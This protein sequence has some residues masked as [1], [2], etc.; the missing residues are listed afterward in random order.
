MK[1]PTSSVDA[2][3]TGVHRPL[4]LSCA[5][6][7]S[8]I[9]SG[10]ALAQQA[11][12]TVSCG[13]ASTCN[14]TNT[15][16]ALS[17]SLVSQG[18][19]WANFS[20]SVEQGQRSDA[21]TTFSGS[22]TITNAGSAPATVGNILVNLQRK[23][24]KTWRTVAT[25]IA[26]AAIGDAAT[27]AL[28]CSTAS[29]ES[30]SSFNENAAS[31][32]M[33]FTDADNNTLFAIND[34]PFV[35]EA[36]ASKTLNYTAKFNNSLLGIPAGEQIR[37]EAIV[38]FANSGGRGGSGASCSG[39]DVNGSGSVDTV[40]RWVRSVPCRTTVSLP[41]MEASN[42]SV[43]L[44]DSPA[45]VSTT[46]TVAMA[47]FDTDIGGGSG[48]ALLDQSAWFYANT[49]VD[50]GAEGGS[51]T[52][53]ATLA[54]AQPPA[55]NEPVALHAEA[56]AYFV[57]EPP[58]SGTDTCSYTQGGWGATPH[59]NNPASL[60]AGGFP[61]VYPSG[62]KVGGGRW[63]HFTS[64]SAVSAYLPAGRTAGGLTSNLTN[65]TTSSAGV[66]GG[67]VLALQLNVDFSNAGL[68]P[69]GFGNLIVDGGLTVSNILADANAALGGAPG[70]DISALNEL[71]SS[72]NESMDNCAATSWAVQHFNLSQ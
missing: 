44:N 46:G 48:A 11:S 57:V 34:P 62:V 55:C 26:N 42:A 43:V 45:S 1:T 51:L 33:N 16:W 17:K 70:Y 72:L 3:R 21:V 9:F 10:V 50:A 19:S 40:E 15:P 28:I 35:L 23:S 5:L 54:A 12:L 7:L 31:G 71:V 47:G 59:G 66:F 8:A 25:D 52:N 63:M 2:V 69:F 32:A 36:G 53:V 39:V 22:L 24:G 60:L 41:I 58:T 61:S 20:V 6:F 56:T 4:L 49:T 67:Q 14:A 64:A 65:P 18:D 37:A 13:I 27:S 29:S 30:L 68:T 38:T